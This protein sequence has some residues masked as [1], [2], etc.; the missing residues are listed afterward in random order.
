MQPPSRAASPEDMEAI[1]N[2]EWLYQ[3]QWQF[4]LC[5]NQLSQF[6]WLRP[7]NSPECVGHWVPLNFRIR[8]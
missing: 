2:K 7:R 1:Q 4:S 5:D 8:I 3:A 6:S